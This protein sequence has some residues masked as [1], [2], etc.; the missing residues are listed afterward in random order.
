MIMA[1][2]LPIRILAS[3]IDLAPL[4]HSADTTSLVKTILS[5]VFGIVGA[6]A[7][8]FITISGFRYIISAGDPQKTAQA[9]EGLIYALV[10]LVIAISAET[11][12][13]F[14]VKNLG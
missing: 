2:E 14:F 1:M 5:I 11:I 8:L 4:P 3:V 13:V 10:G 9:K 12:V 7:F 6:L